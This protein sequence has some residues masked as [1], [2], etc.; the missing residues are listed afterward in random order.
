[1]TGIKIKTQ[2]IKIYGIGLQQSSGEFIVLNAHI[3]KEEMLQENCLSIT[4]KN[5]G[6]EEQICHKCSIR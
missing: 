5:L 3:G 2:Y 6:K 1:M 4:H